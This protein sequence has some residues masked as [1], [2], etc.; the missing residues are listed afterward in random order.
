MIMDSWIIYPLVFLL[1]SQVCLCTNQQNSTTK[2]KNY[3]DIA[4][5]FLKNYEVQATKIYSEESEAAWNYETDLTENN[6][7][8]SVFNAT[9]AKAFSVTASKNA[10]LIKDVDLSNDMARQIRIIRR[11]ALPKSPTDMKSIDDLISNMTNIYSGGKLCTKNEYTNKTRCFE[12]DPDLNDLMAKSR[13]YDELLWGW[14]SWRDKVGPPMRPLYEKL[15]VLLNSG[16]REHE[17]GDYGNFQRSEYEMGNDFQTAIKRLWNEV[18]MLY[19]ELHAYVRYKL[20]EKYPQVPVNGSI[21]AHLLGNMWAQEWSLIYDIVKPFPK[22]PSLDV[23]PNLIKQQ[24]TPKKMFKLAQSFFV[25]LGLDPMPQTFWNKSVI[26]K[27]KGKQMVCHPSAWDFCKGDVRIKMCTR[28]TQ[29]HLITIHHEMGHCEYDLAYKDLPYAYRSGAN[30]GFHEA[31]GDTIALSVENPKHLKSVGL[32]YT[33]GNDT[34]AD[35][36]FLMMQA[37][38]RVAPLPFTLLVDQWRWKVFSGRITPSNYNSEWWRLRMHYQGVMS[39][40]PRTEKDFDPGAKYHVGAN[41]PYISYFVSLILQ[42]QFHRSLCKIAK[43]EGS[44]HE[45]SI[46][47]SKEAGQKFREMLAAGRSRPWPQTLYHLTGE[48]EMTASAI[49]EYF[50]PL[51]QW[52]VKYRLEKG[53]TIGWKKRKMV[54]SPVVNG[55]RKTLSSTKSNSPITK[56]QVLLNKTRSDLTEKGSKPGNNNG[57]ADVS[58]PEVKKNDDAI[59]LGKP[60]LKA[61]LAAMGP[62]LKTSEENSGKDKSL[63]DPKSDILGA[64]PMFVPNK[65]KDQLVLG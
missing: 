36:N 22:V 54:P 15:V 61:A 49:L 8:L 32:L 57:T 26:R 19:Q 33:V 60:D 48:R 5:G 40:V 3:T 6:R 14:K 2:F 18:K 52:L 41:Y 21:Q 53:Y 30:P 56:P 64:K 59:N 39:P 45:C 43:R 20:R 31:I 7:K 50:A 1:W 55:A 17:W 47:K 9:F 25:S 34:E 46:Y 27:P 16:A 63:L 65:I 38:R 42:F 12:L 35:V 29:E 23:T 44:L 10:S 13:D 28:M 11:N 58:F 51:Q 4:L 37:L 24:Y 62:V